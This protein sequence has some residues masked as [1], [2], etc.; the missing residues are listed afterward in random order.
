MSGFQ[1]PG[2]RVL[3]LLG[4]LGAALTACATP[5]YRNPIVFGDYS[6]PDVVRVADD[7]YMVSSSF[8]ATPALPVLHSRDLVTWTIVGHAAPR[9]PSPR[10]DEPQHGMGVWAPSLRHH[11]GRFWIYYGDPDLG[12]F[13]TTAADPRGPWEPLTLIA[14]ARGWIDPCPLWDDDGSMYLVHAWAKSRA[15]FNSVL[16]L[17]RLSPDGRSLLGGDPVT[18]FDGT[19]RHPT[20]E[21]PKF[22]KRNGW[23][24]V[25]APAGGVA[26]GWQT[27]LRA[28]SITGPYEDRI[29]L[30]RGGTA[31]N[32][33]HQGGWVET[34]RG[35]S[36]FVHFQDRGAFGRIVHLQPMRWRDDWPIIGDDP[37]GDG[38]GEPVDVHARPTGVSRP[39]LDA[40][41]TSYEFT[42]ARLGL[43]WQWQANSSSD[44]WS[45]DARRGHLRLFSQ[46]ATGTL[47]TSPALLLQKLPAEQFV[48]TASIDLAGLGADASAGLVVFG[49]DYAL[50]RVRRAGD[51]WIVEQVVCRGADQGGAE[52]VAASAPGAAQLELRV[53]VAGGLALFSYSVDRR[54][55]HDVGDRFTLQPGKWVG[56]KIGL[57][58]SRPAVSPPGAYADVDWFRFR[59]NR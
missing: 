46:P 20:I 41:Q 14:P 8:N 4:V 47:W 23:Y 15:G 6:D 22:Y 26:N 16:T 21:G 29:V 31:I 19:A 42:T 40:L 9:L 2:A 27:V 55:Y 28:R 37:D 52:S 32:G 13:M 50:L 44:W 25:F 33:P 17:R 34:A 39:V 49:L 11:A 51:G 24:Y 12:I 7:F 1:R 5:T 3:L 58:T 45:L 53:T 43:Q 36:W 38:I 57:V 30:R 54:R 59:I 35:E 10:Y 48:A 56:A 18:I